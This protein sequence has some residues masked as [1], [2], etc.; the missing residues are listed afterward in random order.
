MCIRDRWK[1]TNAGQNWE[2][3]SPDLTYKRPKIPVSVGI[4]KTDKMEKMA[5]RGV[6]YSIG[7][8]PLNADVIWAGTDDGRIHLTKDGGLNWQDVTPSQMSSWD[9]VS[10]ID[11]SYFDQNT[12]YVAIN[13]IRKDDMEPYI[14]KTNDGGSN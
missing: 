1:T 11:A 2:I 8:S 5:R 4:Y 10:Q 14:Y 6:I 9:K 3:I 13:A 12:A 7:P